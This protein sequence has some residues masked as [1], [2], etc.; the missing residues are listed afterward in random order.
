MLESRERRRNTIYEAWQV[1]EA[2]LNRGIIS[3]NFQRFINGF[4]G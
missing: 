1:I 4:K 3:L 2:L